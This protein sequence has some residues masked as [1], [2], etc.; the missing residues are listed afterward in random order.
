M[1]GLSKREK[2]VSQILREIRNNN[3]SLNVTGPDQC[4]IYGWR[5]LFTAARRDPVK[6]YMDSDFLWLY[7][8]RLPAGPAQKMVTINMT[9]DSVNFIVK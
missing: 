4:Q 3:F 5:Y 7:D 8:K 9:E 6:S 1:F 2:I